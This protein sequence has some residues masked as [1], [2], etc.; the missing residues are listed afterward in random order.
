[1]SHFAICK[2]VVLYT[3]VLAIQESPMIA[4]VVCHLLR[5]SFISGSTVYQ[6][7]TKKNFLRLPSTCFPSSCIHPIDDGHPSA[8]KTP[9]DI[10]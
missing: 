8:R 4:V 2:E 6:K 5:V 10:T 1:M 3:E 7:K 9:R